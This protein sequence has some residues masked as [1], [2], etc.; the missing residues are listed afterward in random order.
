M[1]K[2][3]LQQIENLENTLNDLTDKISEIENYNP[4]EGSNNEF[5]LKKWTIPQSRINVA[6]KTLSLEDIVDAT[7]H[8]IESLLFFVNGLKQEENTYTVELDTNLNIFKIVADFD[9]NIEWA[10]SIVYLTTLKKSEIVRIIDFGGNTL[11]HPEISYEA[12]NTSM[13]DYTFQ[14]NNIPDFFRSERTYILAKRVPFPPTIYGYTADMFM[15]GHSDHT[16]PGDTGMGYM[17]MIHLN[18]AGGKLFDYVVEEITPGYYEISFYLQNLTV[19]DDSKDLNEQSIAWGIP[20]IGIEIYD[21][22]ENFLGKGLV[23]NLLWEF[24]TNEWVKCSVIV[25]IKDN[26][27]RFRLFHYRIDPVPSWPGSV[28]NK[29]FIAIDDITIKKLVVS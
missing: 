8:Q 6:A 20:S 22:E 3:Q 25:Q 2:I 28:V 19:L 23:N 24:W 9:I 11:S 15:V 10:Y 29:G 4:G 27:F 26:Y 21:N 1:Q 17:L 16:Y 5:S 14:G 12:L 7:T 18:N 13:I